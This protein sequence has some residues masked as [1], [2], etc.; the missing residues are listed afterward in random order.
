MFGTGSCGLAKNTKSAY[1]YNRIVLKFGTSLLTGGTKQLNPGVMSQL[2]DQI[3]RL[4]KAGKEI[5][6]VSSGAIAAG[7]YKLG[8]TKKI[9]GIPFKQVMAPVGQSRVMYT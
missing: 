6:I 7:R 9:K 1:T 2:V 5:L 4:H 3:A 8:V